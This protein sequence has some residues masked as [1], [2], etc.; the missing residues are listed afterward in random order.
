MLRSFKSLS[1]AVRPR[2]HP[3]Y[4]SCACRQAKY[5]WTISDYR[6][7]LCSQSC[8][9]MYR[10]KVFF[11]HLYLL[12]QSEYLD[13]FNSVLHSFPLAV[14]FVRYI[15]LCINPLF[16]LFWGASSGSIREQ[17]AIYNIF[18]SGMDEIA[19]IWY[20][21][22]KVTE[23]HCWNPPEQDGSR[24][25]QNGTVPAEGAGVCLSGLMVF[26]LFEMSYFW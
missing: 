7:A 21:H 8:L 3:D 10:I 16:V 22:I 14:S 11:F 2:M 26:F 24:C 13:Q 4:R 9:F 18:R 12:K 6:F 1:P 20:W 25:L 17:V 5:Q 23:R 15:R 19:V